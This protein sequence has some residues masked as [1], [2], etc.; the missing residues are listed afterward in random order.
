MVLSAGVLQAPRH[1]E[2]HVVQDEV[3]DGQAHPRLLT[4]F[5]SCRTEINNM[6]KKRRVRM[7][8]K[9]NGRGRVA[10][11]YLAAVM[12]GLAGAES[13]KKGTMLCSLANS[14]LSPPFS[15]Y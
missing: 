5:G 7:K 12:N 14:E 9:T 2:A 6:P 4:R 3:H 13:V 11:I 8:T 10:Q 1:A 15:V